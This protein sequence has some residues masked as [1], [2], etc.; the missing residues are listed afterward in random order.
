MIYL[1]TSFIIIFFFLSLSLQ[2]TVL[3]WN[4]PQDKV[5]PATESE[6]HHQYISA[7]ETDNS[8]LYSTAKGTTGPILVNPIRDCIGLV[9]NPLNDVD[10]TYS[11]R[12]QQVMPNSGALKEYH[13]DQANQINRLN[14][15]DKTRSTFTMNQNK[16]NN[17]PSINY[18]IANGGPLTRINVFAGHSRANISHYMDHIYESIESE[19]QNRLAAAP[20]LYDVQFLYG[21]R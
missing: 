15:P 13:T 14:Q 20:N 10:T 5:N 12:T 8:N 2:E 19:S 7:N 6:H 21:I 17:D 11:Y 3:H 9:E 1:C 18:C 4:C 16:L